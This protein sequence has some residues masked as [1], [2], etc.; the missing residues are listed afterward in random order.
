MVMKGEAE[1]SCGHGFKYMNTEHYVIL[2]VNGRMDSVK[3]NARL[4]YCRNVII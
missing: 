3:Q 4:I 1:C 2:I